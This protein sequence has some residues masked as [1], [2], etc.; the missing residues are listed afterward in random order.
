MSDLH[1]SE[2]D[3]YRFAPAAPEESVVYGACCPGW[4]T[5]APRETALDRWLSFI[6]QKGIDRYRRSFGDENVLHAPVADSRLADVDTLRADI[7]PFLEAAVADDSPVV[8]HCLAGL[9][10]TGHVLAAWLVFGRG[11]TPQA[12]IEMVREQKRAPMEP[13]GRGSASRRDLLGSLARVG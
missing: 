13:V 9:G 4:H 1:H 10:R 7:L 12:A 11:Y 2:D 8:V 3:A 6:T 5:A